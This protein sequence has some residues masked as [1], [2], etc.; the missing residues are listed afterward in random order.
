MTSP[1]NELFDI[2]IAGGGIVGAACALACAQRGLGVALVEQR[3]IGSEATSAA[4]GHVVAMDDSEAQFAL[5]RYGQ[6]LWSNLAPTLPPSAEYQRPGTLWLAA[7]EAEMRIAEARQAWYTAHSVPCSLITA[8]ELYEAEP[9]L[10][11]CMIGAMFVPEDAIVNPLAV[12]L[13]LAHRAEALGARLILGRRITAIGNGIIALEDNATVQASHL[14]LAM[15]AQSVDLLPQLPIRKRKGHLAITAPYPGFIHRQL[16]ELSYLNSAHSSD[17][18]SVAF[19]IQPRL[20]G[21]ILIGSSR[22]FNADYPELDAHILKAMLDRAAQYL[23]G[24]PGLNVVRSWTGFRAATPDHL[25]LIGPS[26]DDPTVLLATG[27]EGL[28]ITTSLATGELIADHLTGLTPAISI[29]P[30]LPSRLAQSNHHEVK[31]N[32]RGTA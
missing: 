9:H 16:V 7:N 12:A 28:G 15:G 11:A 13:E 1:E 29:A 25:P 2:A 20:N 32:S 31:T 6:Q 27:H 18:D 19:N 22:Q 17:G 26:I 30:Y 14:V 8:A 24:I 5:T 23:P 21:Q 3:A 10:V 4:M